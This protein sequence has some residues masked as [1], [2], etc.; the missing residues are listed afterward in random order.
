MFQKTLL[1]RATKTATEKQRSVH[2]FHLLNIVS[3]SISFLFNLK[4]GI[5]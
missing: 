1:K 3:S 2:V 4:L 5:L